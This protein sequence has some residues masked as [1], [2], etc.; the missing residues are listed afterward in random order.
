MIKIAYPGTGN[1][2]TFSYDGLGRNVGI[3]ET[4]AGSVTS[5]KQFVRQG[6]DSE[7]ERNASGVVQKQFFARGQ[8][9]GSTAYFYT[10]DHLG[11]ICGMTTV[12]GSF[13]SQRQYDCFGRPIVLSESVT[14]DFGYADYYQHA[15]SGLCLALFRAYNPS[16]AHWLSR[17]PAAEPELN[18]FYYVA[19]DPLRLVD[20]LG[21]RGSASGSGTTTTSTSS[22]S[23][24]GGAAASAGERSHDRCYVCCNSC[25][26]D[27]H[28]TVG[29]Y[30]ATNGVRK[31]M[32][33]AA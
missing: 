13:V 31:S 30:R 19:N 5:T 3:V 21:E 2:S 9:N 28:R 17:D 26:L 1:Y 20:P 22:T 11:S 23:G 24:L 14:P 25:F 15:R 10:L 6:K 18:L 8:M 32:H 33:G 27:K 7:E 12:G 16:Q 29:D 4:T